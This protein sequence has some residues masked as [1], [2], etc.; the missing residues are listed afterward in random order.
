MMRYLVQSRN[1]IFVK[2][3]E[4]LSIAKNIDKNIDKTCGAYSQK[5]FDHA[6]QCTAYV[7]KT[8]SKIKFKKQQKQL[9]IWL[10]IKLLKW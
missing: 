8:S 9:V 6:K 4:I 3:F 10:V 5:P 7:C 1:R 2:G